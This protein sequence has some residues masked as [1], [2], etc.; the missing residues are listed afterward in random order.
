MLTIDDIAGFKL[1]NGNELIGK[2]TTISETHYYLENAVFWD[3][4]QVQENPPKWDVQF[5]PLSPGA[6]PPPDVKHPAIDIKLPKSSLLFDPF[7]LRPEVE[8]KYKQLVSPIALIVPGS[9]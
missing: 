3:V 7:V 6:K 1:I 8:A 4:I 5:F 2:I 9:F